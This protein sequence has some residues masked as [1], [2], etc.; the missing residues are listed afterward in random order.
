M[1]QGGTDIGLLVLW[2]CLVLAVVGCLVATA[3][4]RG[5]WR[6]PIDAVVEAYRRR[7][8]ALAVSLVAVVGAM[9]FSMLDSSVLHGSG[10]WYEASFNDFWR[11]WVDGALVTYSGGFGHLYLLDRTLETAP[12]WQVLIAPVARLGFHLPFPDPSVVL[13]P[14]AFWLAGPLFLGAMV[15]PICAGDRWL[16]LLGV[17]ALGRRLL[18]LGVLAVTLPPMALFGHSEDLVALGAMLYGLAAA[19]EGRSR[20]TG[21]WLGAALAFQFFAFLAVPLALVFIRPRRWMGALVP[22]VVVPLGFLVVPL[23]TE[24][25]ATIR[26][27]LHQ[28]VYDDLGYI[29]PTW[30]LDPGV[31]SFVRAAIALAAVPAAL[32]VARHLPRGQVARANLVLW[33]LAVLFALRVAEPELVPYF[34]APPLALFALDAAPPAV[35]AARRRR[36]PRRLAELV[37]PR[38]RGCP[39]V[40]LAD[41]D[42]ATGRAGLAWLAPGPAPRAGGGI[43]PG[44]G[45]PVGRPAVRRSGRGPQVTACHPVV[46][47][48][49]SWTSWTLVVG[50]VVVVGGTVVGV[51]VVVGGTVVGVVV[52]G[53]VVGGGR[54][55][56]VVVGFAGTLAV[57]VGLAVGLGPVA[58]AGARGAV[59]V[60]EENVSA[61]GRVSGP[62]PDGAAVGGVGEG[63]A[64]GGVD[65][66]PPVAKEPMIVLVVVGGRTRSTRSS[67]PPPPRPKTTT[68]SVTTAAP[69]AAHRSTSGRLA[70]ARLPRHRRRARPTGGGTSP[71]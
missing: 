18:V 1:S 54:G 66:D 39:L 19:L 6:G 26:Q 8:L 40:V 33:T 50:V 52:V 5:G 68:A 45:H 14:R 43:G 53:T 17:D 70:R 34:L 35:V 21:W 16:E 31:A 25:A 46:R 38:G 63:I 28:Q 41:P 55:S 71:R 30:H 69:T 20:A 44:S 24:P 64:G 4:R 60:G 48:R 36:C 13:Y 56:V 47:E 51:V 2:L 37:G 67:G 27:L 22:M 49:W 62:D 42:R 15:L 10:Q 65:G 61:N 3:R 11:N 57:V 23:A 29:S 59:V 9:A 32:V 7:R 58:P 12:A